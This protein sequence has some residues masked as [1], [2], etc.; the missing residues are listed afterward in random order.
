[1]AAA[2]TGM[3]ARV[4]AAGSRRGRSC[5][6]RR[7]G[8]RRWGLTRRTTNDGGRRWA[9]VRATRAVRH[10]PHRCPGWP[11]GL[12]G[13][14][15]AHRS[16]RRGWV[17]PSAWRGSGFFGALHAPQGSAAGSPHDRRVGAP[18]RRQRIRAGHRPGHG[19]GHGRRTRT[20]SH[21]ALATLLLAAARAGGPGP[22]NPRL[23]APRAPPSRAF[24]WALAASFALLV[25]L[26][27]TGSSLALL[28]R[29]R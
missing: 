6:A 14:D 11:A 10:Q 9:A 2:S 12:S 5:R 22:S 13:P 17:L 29:Q 23:A 1:M 7:A 25:A 19:T 20:P 3:G 15:A 8:P 16:P 18:R 28:L 26:G 4:D 24:A 27:V 21:A